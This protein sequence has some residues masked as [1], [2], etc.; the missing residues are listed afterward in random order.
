MSASVQ[1]QAH[2]SPSQ[3]PASLLGI[4]VADCL[5]LLLSLLWALLSAHSDSYQPASPSQRGSSRLQHTTALPPNRVMDSPARFSL[6]AAGSGSGDKVF[7]WVQVFCLLIMAFVGT[8]LWSALDRRR[9]NYTDLYKWFR[10]FLRFAL[11]GQMFAYGL[12]KVIPMQMPFPILT[13]LLE[14][15]GSFLLW[16][17]SGLRSVLLLL[18]RDSSEVRNWWLA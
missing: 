9:A 7:D 13:R 15:F 10:V 5:S 11:A 6:S 8:C 2:L 17:C 12:T 14:P 4:R 18:M 16:A 1:T 3:L